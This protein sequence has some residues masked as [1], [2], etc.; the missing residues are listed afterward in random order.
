[1]APRRQV[2][3]LP[4]GVIRP[5]RRGNS[6]VYQRLPSGPVTIE[7]KKFPRAVYSVIRLDGV[8]RPIAEG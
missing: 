6:V 5:M 3:T 2:L 1:M 8:M 4:R 7:P